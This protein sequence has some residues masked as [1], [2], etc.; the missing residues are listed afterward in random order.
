MMQA[1]PTINPQLQYPLQ[2][3]PPSPFIAAPPRPPQLQQQ[4][5]FS[6][7][8]K[9][10]IISALPSNTS[11]VT[12]GAPPMLRVPVLPTSTEVNPATIPPTTSNTLVAAYSAPKFVSRVPEGWIPRLTATAAERDDMILWI[13]RIPSCLTDDKIKKMLRIC[14]NIIEWNRPVGVNNE[15]KQFGFVTFE[16]SKSALKCFRAFP[17]L[18]IG[19]NNE[20]IEVKVCITYIYIEII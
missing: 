2:N 18:N 1:P 13:G 17:L 12:I 14:G 3:F 4:Q 19:S 10:N 9:P 7:P 5:R 15:L 16:H 20:R 8:A 6:A 11:R